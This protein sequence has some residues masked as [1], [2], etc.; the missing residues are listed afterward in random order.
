MKTSRIERPNRQHV[1][2]RFVP[3]VLLAFLLV[4]PGC[5][6]WNSGVWSESG[7]LLD[8]SGE[9]GSGDA[10]IAT[11]HRSVSTLTHQSRDTISLAVE[12]R[13]VPSSALG[14]E[15][16]RNVDETV[17][18]ARVRQAWMANGLRIGLIN[19]LENAPES[20]AETNGRMRDPINELFA[21]AEVLGAK[22]DG[23]EIIP[24]RPSRRHE[25]PLAPALDNSHTILLRQ[26]SGLIGR[27]LVSPQLLLAVTAETGTRRGQSTLEIRP[28]IHH[29]AVRQKFVSSDTAV[30]IQA[31]RERWDL[32]ELN[33]TWK[34]RPGSTLIIAP[35]VQPTESEPTF[36]LG[37]QMMRDPDHLVDDQHIVAFL[38]I[39]K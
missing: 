27:D 16:W 13:H 1:L 7:K 33:V 37:R 19:S 5:A 2:P 30:R 39:E 10:E 22:S 26:A 23:R 20:D 3:I 34:T 31:G 6:L 8:P 28:E 12:F 35:V 15:M 29:G 17:F 9:S 14:E 11:A 36:G 21:G 25:L 4:A 24:L 38:Q 32:T 18:D